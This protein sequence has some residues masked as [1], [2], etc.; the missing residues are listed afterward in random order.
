[1]A[2]FK[3]VFLLALIV[4]AAFPLMSVSAPSEL[5][6]QHGKPAAAAVPQQ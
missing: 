5:S 6:A 2:T 3:S 4:M 1:M